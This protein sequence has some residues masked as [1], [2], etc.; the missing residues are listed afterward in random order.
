MV[1]KIYR[2]SLPILLYTLTLTVL[3]G[4]LFDPDVGAFDISIYLAGKVGSA[5]GLWL[6]GGL[7]S[8]LLFVVLMMWAKPDFGFFIAMWYILSTIL[9]YISYQVRYPTHYY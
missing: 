8:G 1:R 6:M 9:L 7:L 2:K 5:V 3:A 4:F